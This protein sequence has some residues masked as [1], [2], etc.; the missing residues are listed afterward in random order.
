MILANSQAYKIAYPLSRVVI[1]SEAKDLR[2]QHDQGLAIKHA[3]VRA[4]HR[5]A[6]ACPV[7]NFNP[8]LFLTFS[9]DRTF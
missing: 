4:Q 3:H 7:V 2:S 6:P 1:L 5:C 8:T 9:S